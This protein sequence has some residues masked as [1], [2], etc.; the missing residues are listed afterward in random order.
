L[1]LVSP[2]WLASVAAAV[3]VAG[4]AVAVVAEAMDVVVEVVECP[5]VTTPL[6]EAAA[7]RATIAWMLPVP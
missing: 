7:G 6:S 3:D 1:T 2:R 4:A 5:A